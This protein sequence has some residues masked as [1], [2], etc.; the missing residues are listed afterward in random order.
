MPLVEKYGLLLIEDCAQAHAA[1]WD[2]KPVGTFGDVGCFSFYPTKN[3]TTGE[4]GAIITR[5]VAVA[6]R[7]RLLINHGMKV[8]YYHDLIGYN[9]RMTNIAAA[10]GR[11]QL[12]KLTER[13][14]VRSENAAYLSNRII[15]EQI[16]K[17]AVYSRASHVFHQYTIRVLN[18]RRAEF[19]KLLEE[20]GIG[21]GVFY[22][23]SIP[24]QHCYDAF[25]FEKA[26]PVTDLVKQEVV[27]LP[28]HPAL[29]RFDLDQIVE[30]VNSFV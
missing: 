22:P 29:K 10:I 23:L 2:G 26:F 1:L 14:R 15:N 6:E 28:V 25:H 7:C 24:E 19:L 11:C 27:S 18:G 5:D 20:K 30:A 13:N 9:A 4:G 12:Q 16:Y 21:Y 17:P 8:R 3:M